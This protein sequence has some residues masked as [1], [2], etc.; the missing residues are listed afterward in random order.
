MTSGT[1]SD[2]FNTAQPDGI[3]AIVKRICTN[4]NNKIY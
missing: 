1:D 3:L 2:V 4:D